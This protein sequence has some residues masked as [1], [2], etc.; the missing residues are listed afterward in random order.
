[1]LTTAD[2]AGKASAAHRLCER[3]QGAALS[4]DH[5]VPP[6]RPA[7][8]CRP[9]LARPGDMPKR[10]AL[11]TV[12][13]RVALLHALAHIELNAIDLACDIVARFPGQPRAF[14]GDW[15]A[16]ADD[17]ARHFQMLRRRLNEL[18][19]DYGDLP[20]HDGL[21]QAAEDTAD[22]LLARLA[23]VPMVL[24]AR[25]LD[26]TPAMITRLEGAGDHT[27]AAILRVIYREEIAHVAA[28]SRWFVTLCEE[29]A[30]EPASTW[31][32]IVAARFKGALK[33]PFNNEAR[34]AAG[35]PASFYQDGYPDR[36]DCLVDGVS[37]GSDRSVAAREW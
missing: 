21:W 22:D 14:Y 7:R 37:A 8:P 31:R 13:G 20:A 11:T 26:V 9:Q 30:L 24:E 28:G 6:D 16:V 10:R 4:G 19:A 25:G 3:W 18:G 5:T 17:E 15:A 36:R 2:P 27:S 35:M 33:P 1:V 12:R 34:L 23:I 29:R 32:D